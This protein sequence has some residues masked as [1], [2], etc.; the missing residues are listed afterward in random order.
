MSLR[1]AYDAKLCH[2]DVMDMTPYVEMLEERLA[3]AAAV[4]DESTRRVASSL[5]DALDAGTRL[6]LMAALS[7]F[8]TEV[9]AVLTDRVVETRLDGTEISAAV[10]AAPL[11][12]RPEHEESAISESGDTSRVTLRLPDELKVRAGEAAA[13]EGLSLNAWLARAV[14][15]AL[16]ATGARPSRG[17]RLRGWVEA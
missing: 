17:T 14:Q 3:A 6:A 16:R 7:E 13:R 12:E 9:S 11:A 8:A 4:G 5:G 2:I 15:E 1:L 10:S